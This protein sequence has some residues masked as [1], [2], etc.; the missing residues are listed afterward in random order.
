MYRDYYNI[1]PAEFVIDNR[2][3]FGNNVR[4][5]LSPSKVCTG[6]PECGSTNFTKHG[7]SHRKVRDLSEYGKLVGLVIA[8]HRY[9]CKDCFATWT[10]TFESVGENAKM[11]KRMKTFIQQKSL[12]EPFT[13]ISEELSVSVSTVRRIFLEYSQEMDSQRKLIAPS[14]LGMDENYLNGAYRALYVD[15]EHTRIIDMTADRKLGTVRNWL[16]HLPYKER[17]KCV[18]IDM[19]GSYK[20]AVQIELPEIPIVI[21]KFHVI[22]HVNEALDTIRKGLRDQLSTKERKHIK[23]NRWLLLHNSED[24]DYLEQ[25]RLRDLLDNFPQF[26][27]PH[28]LKE[29]FRSIYNAKTREEAEQRYEEWEKLSVEYPEYVEVSNMV[30]NWY[31]EIFNYFDH[32]YTNAAT[33]SLNRLAKEIAAKGRGYTYDVL[34]M[35]VLYGTKASKPPQYEYYPS[36]LTDENKK[37]F[38]DH[39]VAGSGVDIVELIVAVNEN[40]F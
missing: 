24:L 1:N 27:K 17:V 21:D 32:P 35:K 15:V 13:H 38:P 5:D 30:H 25:K 34:R 20:D 28:E 33:E 9:K 31:S 11:T 36:K 14:V 3:E 22:K 40:N 16:H 4:Y 10:D 2:E 12:R 23:N 18:T 8:S 29:Q 37:I 19:W 6:C 26:E 7:I 39:V